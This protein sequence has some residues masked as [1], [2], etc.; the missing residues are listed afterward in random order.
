MHPYTSVLESHSTEGQRFQI[1]AGQQECVCVCVQ[2]TQAHSRA[3]RPALRQLHTYDNKK[4]DH[5]SSSNTKL[6]S[7]HQKHQRHR[8]HPHE[9]DRKST[10]STNLDEGMEGG[11]ELLRGQLGVLSEVRQRPAEIVEHGKAK[12]KGKKKSSEAR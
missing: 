2:D 5:N 12:Q 9:Y 3:L 10:T 1:A 7:K 11:E 6:T 4:H 8:Q